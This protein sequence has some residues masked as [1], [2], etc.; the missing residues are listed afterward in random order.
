MWQITEN[1]DWA[2]L[3]EQF[4]WVR[5][6][7][8]VAQDSIHHAE[9]DVEIHTQMVVQALLNLPEYQLFSEQNQEI[10]FA[11]ALMH[12]IE[13]RSTT[14]IEVDGRITSAGH[15][16][17]GEKTVRQILYVDILTPFKVREQIAKLVRYHG[18]PLWIFEKPNPQK[19]L[20][21]ASM[22]VDTQLLAMLAKADILGRICGDQADLLYK[23]ELFQAFCEEQNVWGQS[24]VFASDLAKFYYFQKGGESPDYQ[25]FEDGFEVIL[26]SGLP[27]TGKDTFLKNNYKELKIISLDQIRREHRIEPTDK[28]GNGR[29]VQMAKEN[30]REF[31][32]KKQSFVWNATNTSR[33]MREQLIDLFSSYGAKV[34]IIYLEVSFQKLMAQN[35]NREYAVPDNVIHR[36]IERLEIPTESECHTLVRVI[37]N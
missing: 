7:Q 2:S 14:V 31:L 35:R 21:E 25:P 19:A 23:I 15:A 5:D 26:M 13:K 37:A 34:K 17:K 27:G 28:S 32:R 33:Q 4:S 30:A 24:R 9:G 29:V 18:L 1:K 8:G 10:L 16:K 3:K 22:E 6:M 36:L 20:F 12:D 11:A